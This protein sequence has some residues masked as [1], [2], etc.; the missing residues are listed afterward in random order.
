[1]RSGSRRSATKN[2]FNPVFLDPGG[3]PG[4]NTRVIPGDPTVVASRPKGA[5]NTMSQFRHQPEAAKLKGASKQELLEGY[6]G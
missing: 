2:H 4:P 1:M 3:K 5:G 6:S